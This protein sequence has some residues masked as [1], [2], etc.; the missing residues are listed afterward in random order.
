MRSKRAFPLLV[1]LAALALTLLLLPATDT[2]AKPEEGCDGCAAAQL[3][4]ADKRPKMHH[5]QLPDLSATGLDVDMSA[6]PLADDFRCMESG[7][8]DMITIWGSFADDELPRAGPESLAFRLAIHADIPA[9]EVER[10][11]MPGETLWSR[12]FEPGQYSAE[13]VDDM[14]EGWFDPLSGQWERNNHVLAF[15]YDFP[16]QRDPFIQ[17]QGTVYWLEVKDLTPL[18]PTYLFG[19]KTT[20]TDLHW[21]DDAVFWSE[22]RWFP[23]EYPDGH[24]HQAV[25]LDLAFEIGGGYAELEYGDAP[26]GARA[27]AYPSSGVSGSFPTCWSA[28]PAGWIQHNNF[29]AYFGPAFEFETD[30]DAGLCP[31]PGC[32]PPYDQVECFQDRDAGLLIP[33]PFTI[34]PT[35]NVVPCPNSDGTPLGATCQLAAWGVDIDIDV[36]NHMPS[37]T[38]G[39]VNLL[40]DWNQ[41]GQWGGSSTCPGTP[42]RTVPEHVLVDFLVPNPFDGPLSALQP[43]PFLIGP[44]DGFVWARFS[45]TERPVGADWHGEGSF[46]DG[47]TEDYLLLTRRVAERTPTVT[48]T[49]TATRP[50]S[51][52]ATST[53]TRIPSPTATST[54]TSTP[55]P[56]VT[57]TSTERPTLTPTLPFGEGL[58]YGDAPEGE[59]AVAYPWLGV[60][61]S[62]PTCQ[63]LGP[64]GWVQHL[65]FGAFLGPAFDLELDGNAGSCGLAACFPP[66]DRDEC[67]QDRDAG[68]LMPEPF[69]IDSALNVVPCPNSDGTQLGLTCH[70]ATWGADID[71]EV[72]NHMPSEERAFVNVLMDWNQDGRWDGSSPCPGHPLAAADEHVLVDFPVP[73]GYDGPL[74]A[75]L[76]PSFLIGPKPRFVW[77][78]FSITERP[79]GVNW[80]GEGSF[81]DGESEDYL[82]WVGEEGEPTP[83][84][85]PTL[86]PTLTATSRVTST[87]AHRLYLPIV[88]KRYWHRW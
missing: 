34:D 36:H 84:R 39:F 38:V 41:D 26:E 50:P 24:P 40:V 87:P 35:P 8:I 12:T 86:T 30:G 18:P 42:P 56:T 58:E 71:L 79:V 4:S 32:F 53:E 25:T 83:T 59:G 21:Q 29:G 15:R 31:P 11:S 48:S 72:H 23:M 45:I 54:A 6:A 10:W 9:G 14:P 55:T 43:P 47:E 22:Q 70:V 66:Y 2:A 69:T 44:N 88:L 51:P 76:P 77:A 13:L 74:S 46:E 17:R 1:C 73:N 3:G 82:L 16:I 67:F 28:G 20:P 7:P 75:L 68:L 78:R 85:P 60:N 19:W 37:G 81:E 33:E 5:P 52:T 63:T 27:I 57:A 49:A 65:N 61:G 64:A 80:H 62:F